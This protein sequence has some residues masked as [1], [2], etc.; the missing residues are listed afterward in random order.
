MEQIE[1]SEGHSSDIHNYQRPDCCKSEYSLILGE[2]Q[3]EKTDGGLGGHQGG[4]LSHHQPIVLFLIVCTEFAI[5][6]ILRATVVGSCDLKIS[7]EAGYLHV[8]RVPRRHILLFST[9]PYLQP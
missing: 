6:V 4:V 8:H 5:E 1:K 3:V 2:S 9:S 7:I